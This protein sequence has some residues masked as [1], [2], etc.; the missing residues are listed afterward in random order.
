MTS[1]FSGSTPYPGMGAREVM[2]RVRDGYR[3]ERPSHCHPDLYKIIAKCWAGDMNKRPDFSELRQVSSVVQSSAKRASP[4]CVIAAGKDGHKCI[5]RE[6]T[7]FTKS[8]D[9]L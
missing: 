2:R 4:G 1:V 3:L 7:K 5:A 6:V 8:W 9:R